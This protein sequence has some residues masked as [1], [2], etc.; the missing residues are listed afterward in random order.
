ML[1][2]V[3]ALLLALLCIVGVLA[4]CG[5][6]HAF[7]GWQLQTQATC[8]A[9]GIEVGFCECGE[10]QTRA[11]PATGEHQY[12]ANGICTVCKMPK[13]LFVDEN[14]VRWAK[15]EWGNV[16]QYDDLPADLAYGGTTV[17]VLVWN[18]N[19]PEFIQ[20]QETEEARCSSIYKR[21]NAVQER[22]GVK[23]NMITQ[24][25]GNGDSD[26]Y[27]QEVKYTNSAGLHEFDIL[28][29]YS[30]TAGTLLYHGL[31]YDLSNIKNSY[32]D[33][34]K[35]WW[36]SGVVENVKIGKALYY[37]TGDISMTAID[38][39]QVVFFNKALL[40]AKYNA[41]A[42]G[43]GFSS[44]T[45]WLYNCV[46][47]GQW[48]VDAFVG[49]LDNTYEN[50]DNQSGMTAGDIYG[51]A[52]NGRGL[53]AMYGGAGLRMIE[54]D[55]DMTLKISADVTGITA[56]KLVSK[57]GAMMNS[58]NAFGDNH[59]NDAGT[60]VYFPFYNGRSYFLIQ[61]MDTAQTNLISNY[62]LSE[63]YG[64]LPLPKGSV[65][66]EKYCTVMNN[67]FSVYGIYANFERRVDGGTTAEMLSAVLECWASESYR[68]CIP[69]IFNSILDKDSDCF[70]QKK[71]M[72]ELIRA[73]IMLD[74]ARV[75]PY[76]LTGG[77]SSDGAEA[78]DMWFALACVHNDSWTTYYGRYLGNVEDN[79][80]D[81]VEI[82]LWGEP[83]DELG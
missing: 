73:S 4:S 24:T 37:L 27:A 76:I 80:R 67:A 59:A 16:R 35:P 32:L 38:Q 49:L 68:K 62:R 78:P 22:L 83:T 3:S 45:E 58:N 53:A 42:A 48:T 74:M 51:L 19:Q 13:G 12:S 81:F 36:P 14:G 75:F 34:E 64:I 20:T 63:G 69:A 56:T 33:L 43:E 41:I 47:K 71:K 31:W 8:G 66:Q 60:S 6:V 54:N 57:L 21:N 65:A 39:A 17:K 2:R 1:K 79:L 7:D 30:R 18:S 61:I 70:E 26:P 29:C 55:Q 10:S 15:D 25:A 52:V 72:L 28:A 46:E 40:N 44:A 9:E 82:Y 77:A 23:L 11:I 5:H 50:K